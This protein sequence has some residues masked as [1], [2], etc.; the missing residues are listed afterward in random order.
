MKDDED[1]VKAME[2]KLKQNDEYIQKV[3]RERDELKMK[4]HQAEQQKS[5]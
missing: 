5:Q 2:N 4:A 3:L 1:Q